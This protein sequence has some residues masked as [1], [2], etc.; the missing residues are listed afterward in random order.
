[1][2][3]DG[4]V[5]LITGAGSGIGRAVAR[6]LA[7]GSAK[8]AALDRSEERVK[9]TVDEIRLMGVEGGRLLRMSRGPTR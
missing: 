3:F 7:R 9:A 4:R 6:E 8:I 2:N 1:M 5:A